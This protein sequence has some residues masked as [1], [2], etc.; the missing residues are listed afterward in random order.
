MRTGAQLIPGIGTRAVFSFRTYRARNSQLN[1]THKFEGRVILVVPP[2]TVPHPAMILGSIRK[3]SKFYRLL[4]EDINPI[5]SY[6][7]HFIT[8]DQDTI[9]SIPKD[10]DPPSPEWRFL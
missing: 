4:V 10:I 6:K 2:Q 7:F 1:G 5:G 9:I 8:L 3:A